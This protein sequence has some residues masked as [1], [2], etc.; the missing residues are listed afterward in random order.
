[1]ESLKEWATVVNALENGD[2][3]VL[4][5]KGGILD[6]ASGFRIESKKF[7]LFQTSYTIR[8]KRVYNF[9]SSIILDNTRNHAR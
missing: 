3:T 7:T 4:L 8:Y 6:V 2:Q 1:V 5:R 9:S